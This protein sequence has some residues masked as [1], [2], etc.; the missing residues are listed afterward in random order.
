MFLYIRSPW[1][2][3]LSQIWIRPGLPFVSGVVPRGLSEGGEAA[4]VPGVSHSTDVPARSPVDLQSDPPRAWAVGGDG[5]PWE[6][7]GVCVQPMFPPMR[8]FDLS[9]VTLSGGA[10]GAARPC[11]CH[12]AWAMQVCAA[13]M[14]G[15]CL[16]AAACL[17]LQPR[18][19][20]PLRPRAALRKPSRPVPPVKHQ[21][22]HRMPACG[23]CVHARWRKRGLSQAGWPLDAPSSV[24][25]P[26]LSVCNS[27]GVIA[28]SCGEPCGVFGGHGGT[29]HLWPSRAL[30][31]GHGGPSPPRRRR[32]SRHGGVEQLRRRGGR[33]QQ[34]LGGWIVH[35]HEHRRPGRRFVAHRY[36]MM[37]SHV[38]AIA[39]CGTCDLLWCHGPTC[40][41]RR[42]LR[43]PS[44]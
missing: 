39:V 8:S 24:C 20:T 7:L 22:Q 33:W 19:P 1:H 21:C 29:P 10:R 44:C 2:C 14:C 6:C 26:A 18:G 34:R 40:C 23:G 13:I 41:T 28:A 17:P 16:C 12:R 9:R 30:E 32:G 15:V 5:M 36:I 4:D 31:R 35:A 11:A 38:P 3:N 37:D 25:K 43:L 42:L 27:S